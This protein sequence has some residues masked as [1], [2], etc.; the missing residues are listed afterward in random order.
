MRADA[1]EAQAKAVAAAREYLRLTRIQ[2]QTGVVDYLHVV[3][4][5]QTLMTNE[6]SDAQI[7]N[8]RMAST[9]LLIKALGG[10]W[11]SQPSASAEEA[12][13]SDTPRT[14]TNK[15]KDRESILKTLR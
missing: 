1:A 11:N 2:Y 9:V 13:P 6:L 4:A 12:E 8:Q 5:E 3:N 7:L 10:G 14:T 15:G